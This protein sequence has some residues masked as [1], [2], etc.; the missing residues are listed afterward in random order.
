MANTFTADRQDVFGSMR[1]LIG[2]LAMGDGSSGSAAGTGLNRVNFVV[3][4]GSQM[5]RITWSASSIAANTAASA[6]SYKVMVF[7]E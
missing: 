7:G 6:A 2:T 1:V 5:A 4:L 3:G